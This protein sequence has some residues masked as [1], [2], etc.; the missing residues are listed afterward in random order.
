M[1]RAELQALAD[2]RVG[3][4]QLL[5]QNG[6]NQGAY[7]LVG[8]AI[9][10]AL[11]AAVAKQI[12]QHDFPDRKLIMDSYTHNLEQLL[13]IS[14]LKPQLETRVAADSGFEVNWTTVKDWNESSRYDSTITEVKARDLI[15]A[16]TDQGHG[17][18]PW[19][20]TLW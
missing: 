18:L 8:Y 7:Y 11:K 10:C 2:L 19:L 5:L 4:A 9:E 13:A 14:G 6:R 16:V 15:T 3:D 20:K 17:V 12:R 1:N